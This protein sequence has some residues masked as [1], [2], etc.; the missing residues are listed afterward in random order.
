MKKK[1]FV[2]I[3]AIFVVI[4]V[5]V[6]AKTDNGFVADEE[7]S[8]KKEFNTTTFVAGNNIKMSSTVDGLN[9]VA[10][11]N[12]RLS[13]SQDYLFTAGNNIN[14]EG[15]TAKDVFIA[16]NV[17]NVES[18]TIRDLYAVGTSIRIESPI[19]RNL[20]CGGDKITINSTVEGNVKL[21]ADDIRIGKEAVI[22]GTL[23]YPEDA[24]ISISE[25]AEIG[26]TKTYA[27]TSSVQIT[28]T[29]IDLLMGIL[30][31]FLSLLLIA[32]ILL[33]MNKKLFKNIQK[34]EKTV[35]DFLKKMLI[36]FAILVLVPMASIIVMLTII[37]LPLSIIT[38]LLY[39]ILIYL[40]TI[41]SAYYI[42]HWILGKNKYNEYLVLSI[43]LLILTLAK[44]IP[45]I[46][47]LISF[48]SLLLGL[49][50]FVEQMKNTYLDNQK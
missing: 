7:V 30:M 9:F 48:A 15:V 32:F 49:G 34:Q 2:L 41:V 18:S 6:F 25:S 27:T 23:E 3:M 21:A 45:V 40:S 47:G 8:L 39:G 17:L 42:A 12:I 36:G 43:A 35:S 37:G 16:G 14:L 13:S 11:N 20:Y 1:I 19:A 26:K 10:G 50:L 24:E 46:G 4:A 28:T 44:L 38:L 33:T 22:L 31:N 5:P 29:W